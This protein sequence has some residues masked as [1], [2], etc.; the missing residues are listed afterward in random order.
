MASSAARRR[1]LMTVIAL[2]AAVLAW[3]VPGSSALAVSDY[4]AAI[5]GV[6]R[7]PEGQAPGDN[8]LW[9][10]AYR[11]YSTGTVAG[12]AT[13]LSNVDASGTYALTGLP[14]GSYKLLVTD[15]DPPH[16]FAQQ[17]YPDATS[18]TAGATVVVKAGAVADGRDV[19]LTAPVSL[20][21]VLKDARGRSTRGSVD[22]VDLDGR[23]VAPFAGTDGYPRSVTIDGLHPGSYKVRGHLYAVGHTEWYSH[24][25]SFGAATPV[26][27]GPQAETTRT[28]TFH[29]PQ[30]KN[31]RRPTVT[32]RG[33][34]L[35]ASK[36]SWSRRPTHFTYHLVR[37][38]HRV[39]G[40]IAQR[41]W[42]K[43]KDLG[44][45]LKVCVVVSRDGYVDG[46]A[47][48]RYSPRIRHL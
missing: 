38:G 1:V 13:Q 25:A 12:R 43:K 39:K 30:L 19:T 17:W 23:P 10:E 15:H 14:A 41:Y 45:R 36:G 8:Y 48:S 28:F 11:V 32:L 3:S 2:G 31:V 34:D 20:T 35:R 40:T 24:R 27:V 44:H 4:P 29:P 6:L 18:A 22:V 26:V 16:R 42:V 9:V 21:L 46:R 33:T 47:C 7:T 5:T 37:D